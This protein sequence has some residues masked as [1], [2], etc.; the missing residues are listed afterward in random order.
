MIL[1]VI[2]IKC[3]LLS[4]FTPNLMPL[5]IIYYDGSHLLNPQLREPTMLWNFCLIFTAVV[6]L[7]GDSSNELMSSFLVNASDGSN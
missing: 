6:I 4:V 5:S 1:P 3:I 7:D 2:L